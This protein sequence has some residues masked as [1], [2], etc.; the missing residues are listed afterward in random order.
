MDD[1]M[2]RYGKCCRPLPGEPIVGFLTRTTGVSIHAADCRSIPGLPPDRLLEVS[3]DLAKAEGNDFS[4]DVTLAVVHTENPNCIPQII[5]T[6][7]S[8]KATITD[9]HSDRNRRILKVRLAVANYE[10]YLQ[11]VNSLRGLKG[12]V[13][14]VDRIRTSNKLSEAQG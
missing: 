11:V 13:T 3:W 12:L 4:A 14:S 10:N 8:S 9:F 7:S 6:I 2:I 5:N 1:I